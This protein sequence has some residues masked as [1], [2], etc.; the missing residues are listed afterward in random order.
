[1]K[2]LLVMLAGP[3]GAGKSTFHEAYL[4]DLGLPFLN[5]DELSARTGMGAYEAADQI[6]ALRRLFVERQSGFITESVLSDPVGDKVN[7]LSEAAAKGF[8]VHLIFIGIADADLSAER[9]ASRAAAGGHEVPR[10]KIMARF[11]RTIA[12]LLRAIARLPRV[13]IYDNSSFDAPFR[14]LAEYRF[15]TLV[16]KSEED[17]PEWAGE[18]IG[19][20]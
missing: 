19:S 11:P 20:S 1:M 17:L 7:F 15:G 2:P 3:N 16:A 4:S 13:T 8:D 5:A 9:V 12:N 14:F 18:I 6:A 10:E